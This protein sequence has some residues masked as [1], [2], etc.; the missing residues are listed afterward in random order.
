VKVKIIS[1]NLEHGGVR[2]DEIIEFLKEQDADIVLSQE[3]FSTPDDSVDRQ[4]RSM[5]LMPGLLGYEYADFSAA[6]RDFDRTD[7][8]GQR[9]N[10]IFSKYPLTAKETVF[11]DGEYSETYRDTPEQYP[12]CPRNLQHVVVHLP[13][14][15]IDV[16]NIQGVWDLDGDNYSEKRKRMAETVIAE[17]KDLSRVILA[18]DTNAKP[19]NQAII[20]IEEHLKSVFPKDELQTTFN[21]R[22]K[23][24]PG[25]ATAAVD[26]ILV[27]PHIEVLEKS[28]PDVDVSDH[29]PLIATLEV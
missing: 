25:Y 12:N 1:I 27:S 17:T 8:K 20:D 29:L 6:F 10:G 21:M 26:M 23:T 14:C 19:T 3:T 11:F 18:G 24:N 9:G 5:Q 28:C 13:D 16:F 7:G 15:D 22:V 2:F 4:Y